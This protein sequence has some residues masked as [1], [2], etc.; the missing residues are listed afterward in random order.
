MFTLTDDTIDM[1]IDNLSGY[2]VSVVASQTGLPVRRV[3]E[4]F[5]SS[6]AYALLGDKE[7]GYYWDSVN[8]LTDK[9]VAEAGYDMTG[10]RHKSSRH[11]KCP[12][13]AG[14]PAGV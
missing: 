3:S 2:I 1:A 7:T 14:V 5:F 10:A 4:A 8:E 9:F 13:S 12:G 6:D 11:G